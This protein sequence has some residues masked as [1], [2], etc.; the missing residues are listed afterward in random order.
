MLPDL[1]PDA[2]ADD[3]IARW[4]WVVA[5]REAVIGALRTRWGDASDYWT[6][7]ATAMADRLTVNPERVAPPLDL[8]LEAV[9][10]RTTVL[11]VGAGWGRFAIPLA[12]AARS[13]VAV[14]PAEAL[15]PILRANMAA[16]GV[17][18]DRLRI[19]NAPWEEA[20][21]PPADVVLC[22]NV[23]SPIAEAGEFVRKLDAHARRRCYVVLRATPL[24]APLVELWR[25]IHGVPYPREPTHADAYAVLDALGI[26]AEVTI[27]P[28]PFLP[29]RFDTPE[30]ARRFVRE[31]I[32]LGP[33]GHDPRADALVDEWLAGSLAPDGAGWRVP[34]ATARTAVIWWEKA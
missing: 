32:W 3:P 8:V 14:E 16:A 28:S 25:A 4:R 17:S 7:R 29:W 34:A 31:R 15:L 12:R 13:L 30:D 27:C 18:G 6:V 21:V 19:V 2:L 23:L 20:K 1:A 9:D 24:D 22:A 5:R 26:A 10:S 11:D 33:A